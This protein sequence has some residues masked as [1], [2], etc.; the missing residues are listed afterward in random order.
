[1]IRNIFSVFVSNFVIIIFGFINS[2]VFPKLMSINEYSTYQTFTLFLAYVN[3]LNIGMSS[4]LFIK[5]GGTDY[6]VINKKDYKSE[7]L[8]LIIVLS[9]FTIFG[10]I[11]SNVL[12]NKILLYLTLCIISVNTVGTYKALYQAWNK[13]K[14]YSIINSVIPISNTLIALL[15]WV[16][17]GN[18]SA[19]V[20]IAPYIIVNGMFFLYLFFEFNKE[21]INIK[22]GKIFGNKNYSTVGL[23]IFVMIG[24]FSYMVFNSIGR[25]FI[26]V[27]F[28][29]YD[30]AMYSFAISMQAT[31]AILIISISQP[32]YPEL[33]SGK[34]EKAKLS[35]IKEL[36]LLFGSLSG[37][38]YFTFSLIIKTF[39]PNYMDSLKIIA[40]LFA[41]FPA[42]AIINCLYINL[43]KIT[44]QLRKYILTLIIVII[45]SISLNALGVIIYK[46]YISIASAVTMTYFIWMWYSSRHF[47]YMKFNIRDIIYLIGYLIIYFTTTIFL[48]NIVGLIVYMTAMIFLMILVYRKTMNEYKNRLI[49]KLKKK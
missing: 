37:C 34:I 24:N 22:P 14:K 38:A 44:R 17:T 12:R 47:K 23:G 21:T 49:F 9:I 31:I 20:I 2:L 30:F 11:I 6:H 13:F 16:L 32:L 40:I 26:K 36:L 45:I 48:E 4:G 41:A 29:N 33:A 7:I 35:E 3:I 43:Y 10:L 19:D 15:I 5:Y 28:S 39:I 27:L 46:N 18:L 8:F 1:M 25:L 42:L